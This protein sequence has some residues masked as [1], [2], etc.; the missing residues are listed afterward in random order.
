MDW[1]WWFYVLLLALLIS[2]VAVA[3][4]GILGGPFRHKS[5]IPMSRH[6]HLQDRFQSAHGL[7][8]RQI[9]LAILEEIL[10]MRPEIQ[11]LVDQVRETHDLE[12]AAAAALT[13]IVGQAADLKAQVADLQAKLA[14]GTLSSED[15]AAAV[16]ATTELHDSATALQS[17]VPAGTSAAQVQ[18]GAVDPSKPQ[19]LPGTGQSSPPP[20]P[21]VDGTAPIDTAPADGTLVPPINP[22]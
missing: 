9:M 8:D 11:A 15:I 10:E 21:H 13:S 4:G 12:T 22:A 5:D 18:V 6:K 14:A 16:A 19:P 1:P 2:S 17:A 3:I 20:D 7:S